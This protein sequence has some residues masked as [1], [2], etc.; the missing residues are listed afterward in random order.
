MTQIK[1]SDSWKYFKISKVFL[2]T[3]IILSFNKVTLQL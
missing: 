2:N 1:I 3:L